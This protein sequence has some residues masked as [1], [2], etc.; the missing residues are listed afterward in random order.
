MGPQIQG[1]KL[2]QIIN[3]FQIID[4]IKYFIQL[5]VESRLLVEIIKSL[6]QGV[7]MIRSADT[8]R[9]LTKSKAGTGLFLIYKGG[10]L[11]GGH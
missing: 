6:L 10:E 5:Q 11:V 3:N 1:K 8:R 7:K 4:L 9:F 2:P